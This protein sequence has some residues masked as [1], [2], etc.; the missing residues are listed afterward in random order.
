MKKRDIKLLSQKTNL[1]YR[2]TGEDSCPG[3]GKTLKVVTKES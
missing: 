3:A 2:R 1:Y